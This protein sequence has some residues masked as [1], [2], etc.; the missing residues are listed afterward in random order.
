[1]PKTHL[2]LRETHTVGQRTRERM[3]GAAA[4]GVVAEAGVSLLGVSDARRGFEFVRN[5]STIAQVLACLEGE[6][7]VLVDGTWKRCTT[8]RV[9]VTPP[10]KL[11]AYH[12]TRAWRVCWVSWRAARSPEVFD[13]WPESRVVEADVQPLA[14]SIEGMLCESAGEPNVQ[15]VWMQLIRHYITQILTPATLDLRLVRLWRRVGADLARHW[16]ASQLAAI[17]GVSTEQLRRLC[18]KWHGTTPMRHVNQLRMQRAAE[19][20][21]NDE[22][23]VEAVARMVGYDNPFAFSTACRRITGKRPSELRLAALTRPDPA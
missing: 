10:G 12:A 11:H 9:Y 7:R 17:A 5:V 14:A 16:D 22:L 13:A 20:L 2:H 23:K 18:L 15:R 21:V 4:S 19:L 3:I 8:G 6:G 1:M